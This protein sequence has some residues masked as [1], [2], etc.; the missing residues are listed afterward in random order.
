MMYIKV[1][2]HRFIII[3][4]KK[5]KLAST[6]NLYFCCFIAKV[7]IFYYLLKRLQITLKVKSPCFQTI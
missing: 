3:K 5:R 2:K 1:D 7:S 4:N 6:F